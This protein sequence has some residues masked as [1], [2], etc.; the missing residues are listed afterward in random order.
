MIQALILA[1]GIGSRLNCTID[2]PKPLILLG[3]KPLIC[4]LIESLSKKGIT[5]IVIVVGLSGKV[6]NDTISKYFPQLHIT[7]I[8]QNP[9]MG[10]G[11]AVLCALPVLKESHNILILNSDTPF[12]NKS[13]DLMLNS[14]K[15]S[16][17]TAQVDNPTNYGRVVMNDKNEFLK[18]VE[19]KDCNTDELKIN[20]INSGLY[21]FPCHLLL[22]F[23]PMLQNKNAQKEYYLTDILEMIKDINVKKLDTSLIYEIHNINTF[24]DFETA[25]EILYAYYKTY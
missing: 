13:L 11:H 18:I 6:I 7:Y 9:A 5:D 8:T 2:N 12:L 20:W 1:A 10:T 25:Q 23:I 14:H 21:I 22:K 16:L 24:S 17:L 15:A 19:H 4:Y 3:D